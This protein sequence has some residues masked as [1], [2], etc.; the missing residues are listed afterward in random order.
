MRIAVLVAASLLVGLI[1][2]ARALAWGFEAHKYITR[3]AIDLL[4]P[5]LKP[6]YE[7]HR[8]EVVVRAVD[9]DLWRNV[10]W[11]D[12]PNHFI[13]FGVKEYGEF[14]FHALPREL[15]AAIEKFGTATLKRN[16]MLPWRASEIFGDLRRAFEGFAHGGQYGPAD[17]VLFSAALA[18]YIQD[19][20]QPFHATNN[21]DGQLTGN[22]G[23]HGRFERDLFE[24]FQA[25][26]AVN[27]AA[28]R[29]IE[30][31]RDA[32]FDAAL[33]GYRL[34]DPILE[35]DR[36]A[37]RGKDLYDEAYF[38][39]L[40]STTRPILER[41]LADAITAT[42]GVILGAWDLAG[43]PALVLPGAHPIEK[44]KKPQP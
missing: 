6:F 21:Y 15:G 26:L 16:G 25:R 18:H 30:N 33:A 23:I 40:F 29:P 34:V 19:A 24:K 10:G 14:P 7:R 20:H 1:A 43:R 5:D 42:A 11:D 35:A 9:P 2:P 38:E 17:T 27:P 37:A 36:A 3:R 22:A 13:D 44:G 8:D 31:A 28:P 39:Q 4:P 12:D 41:R 32:V